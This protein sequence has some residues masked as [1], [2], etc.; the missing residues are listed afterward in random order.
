MKSLTIEQIE[1]VLEKG[2]E[3]FKS[4]V[5]VETGTYEGGTVFNCYEFFS[6]IY[7]IELNKKVL[8]TTINKSKQMGIDNVNFYNGQSQD[9][10]PLIIN[11]ELNL[12]G[13]CIF[14]LDAHYTHNDYGLTSRG[15]I[16]VP[17][18]QEVEIICKNFKHQC[19]IIIDDADAM[20][21]TNINETA[22]ADW[23]NI[24]HDGVLNAIGNRKNT[25]Y[26]FDSKNGKR[27]NDRLV[28]YINEYDHKL[29]LITQSE[30]Q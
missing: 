17:L 23:S 26:Y 10:L 28:L 1:E 18:I 2:F 29:D 25:W 21:N 27:K 24:N 3:D 4:S 16:D 6:K 15:D 22:Q 9:L 8:E 30:L 5:L 13:P 11:Q 14:F 19:I 12:I 20:G 7:T